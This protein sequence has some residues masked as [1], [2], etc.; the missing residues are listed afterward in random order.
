MGN[1]DYTITINTDSES[2]D[3]FTFNTTE[4]TTLT[5]NLNDYVADTVD[6]NNISWDLGNKIDPSRV[7]K[8]C[9]HY[10]AL[11]KA[12]DNFYAIYKMVDQDYKGNIEPD[13][14]IPF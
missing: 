12:W 7:E 8:M 11:K 10:P 6:L 14:E 3:T 4:A 2:P 5:Y 9:E 13:E 1:D